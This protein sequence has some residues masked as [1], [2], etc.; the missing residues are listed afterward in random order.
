MGF[1][2]DVASLAGLKIAT[3]R[4]DEAGKFEGG[5][6]EK[7][8]KLE[9]YHDITPPSTPQNN[10]NA[11]R[12]LSRLNETWVAMLETMEE[13]YSPKLWVEAMIMASGMS[14]ASVPTETEGGILSYEKS[15]ETRVHWTA[16]N[17][18]ARS[19]T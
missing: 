16:L 19:G 17:L 3:I 11:E 10:G 7:L 2:A 5:F 1:I 8:Y 6:Q 9:I 18:S 4:I 13:G 14:N 12:T 15:M